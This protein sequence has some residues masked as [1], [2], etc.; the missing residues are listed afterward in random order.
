MSYDAFNLNQD[1]A[2]ENAVPRKWLKYF[3]V[4]GFLILGMGSLKAVQN[5]L[6]F[7][8]P[9]FLYLQYKKMVLF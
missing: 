9:I 4:L 2:E 3:R 6:Y 1:M 5:I 7:V 8:H